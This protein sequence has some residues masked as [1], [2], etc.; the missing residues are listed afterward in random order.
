VS[1]IVRARSPYQ[2]FVKSSWLRK[3]LGQLGKETGVIKEMPT[4]DAMLGKMDF[5]RASF[6]VPREI[7][8]LYDRLP[9]AD[10]SFLFSC[11]CKALA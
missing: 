10:S 9:F 2:L 1:S 3:Q 5:R 4:R 8:G 7:A 11:P 6:N